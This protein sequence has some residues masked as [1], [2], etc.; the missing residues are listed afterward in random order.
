VTFALGAPLAVL[1]VA[2]VVLGFWPGLVDTLTQPAARQLVAIFA[3]AP[4]L[5]D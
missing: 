1:T 5:A 3:N 4:T 2:V